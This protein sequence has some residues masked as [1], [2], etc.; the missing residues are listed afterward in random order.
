MDEHAQFEIRQYAN[1]IG[2]EIV[3][4]W[5]PAAWKSFLDYMVNSY[6]I[7]DVEFDIIKCSITG[8]NEK[9][10][11]LAKSL[12]WIKEPGNGEEEPY[13]LKKNFERG[14]FEERLRRLGVP[15]PW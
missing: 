4:K 8:D 15:I 2:H 7:R 3:A 11:E 5:C 13:V 1:I 10:I 12:G 14:E 6:R 9:A